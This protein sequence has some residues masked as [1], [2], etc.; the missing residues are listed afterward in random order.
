VCA[1]I[2]T[3]AKS[4]TQIGPA[5]HT[6]QTDFSPA[7]WRNINA[8]AAQLTVLSSSIPAFDFSLYALWTLRDATESKNS[9]TDIESAK[10]WF[11]YAGEFLKTLSQEGKKLDGKKGIEGDG[12][13]GKEWRGF[14]TERLQVWESAIKQ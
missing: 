2:H 5:A 8:F 9:A 10:V 7:Q 11:T 6:T 14:N 4:L 13:E 12:Y 3:Y 1:T